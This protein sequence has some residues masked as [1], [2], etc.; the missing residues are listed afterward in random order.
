MSMAFA[1]KA[2]EICNFWDQINHLVLLTYLFN[3]D[4]L[5]NKMALF[6][7]I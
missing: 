4:I 7:L 2:A 3:R 1:F 5:L 6:H